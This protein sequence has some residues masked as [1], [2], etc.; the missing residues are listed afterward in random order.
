VELSPEQ[1]ARG[2]SWPKDSNP[3]LRALGRE[4][5]GRHHT[6]EEILHEAFGILAGGK[7]QFDAGHIVAPGGDAL[8]RFFFEEKR[9]GAE[10]L[11]GSF[12]MLMRAA[13]V[14]ARLVSGYR[15]GTLVAL[16]K[17]V[18]VKRADAHAWVEIWQDGKG[19]KRVE[20]KDI[21]LPPEPKSAAAPAE[22]AKESAVQMEVK[23]TDAP[24]EV[25][26]AEKPSKAG[27]PAPIRRE[28]GW[29]LPGLASLFGHLQKW[30]IKYDP[31]RQMEILKGVGLK[32]SNWL[33]LLF[34]GVLGV[35]F[36]LGS[37]L[38]AAWWRARKRVD[39][40]AQSWLSFC[41]RLEKFGLEKKAQECP[42]NYLRRISRERPELAAAATD[43]I[44]R[45]LDIRYGSAASPEA[46]TLFKRQVQRFISMT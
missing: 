25:K 35:L 22:K 5:A 41:R 24:P 20:P 8:D 38:C 2:L 23:K 19:W 39:R 9:G 30:V 29:K 45:Y 11:A 6:T 1:R 21:V 44:S 12:V 7:Y 36:L 27:K 13:G 3:R 17:F 18:I 43:I 31:E 15:G 26:D 14:P 46:A 32:E 4:L 34:G 28:E 10:Y 42:R 33:D 16:T 40:V 37:Y